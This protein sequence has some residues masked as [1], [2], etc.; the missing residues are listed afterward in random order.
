MFGGPPGISLRA[1]Q[2]LM[3]GALILRAQLPEGTPVQRRMQSSRRW[4]RVLWMGR[5]A[6]KE[7]LEEPRPKRA[8]LRSAAQPTEQ[9]GSHLNE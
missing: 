9:G 6:W 7:L 5:R 2:P 8:R 4:S 1:A 3:D